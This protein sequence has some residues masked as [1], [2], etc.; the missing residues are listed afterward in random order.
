LHAH[1]STAAVDPANRINPGD[2][3]VTKRAF[4]QEHSP[5]RLSPVAA[6]AAAL[7]MA[8]S[9]AQ[10]QTA[11]S[12]QPATPQTQAER[13]KAEKEKAEREK[14]ATQTITVTG[15]R[16]GIENAINVKKNADS[17]VEAIS[18]EDIGKLP[19]TSVAEAISRLP[20]LSSQRNKSTGR[21]QSV[22]VRGLAPDFTTGTLN[23]RE[24][25]ST[26]D[27]RSVDFDQFPAEL[28]GG[29]TV[30]KSAESSQL[31]QG[32]G[33][34]IDLQTVRP[35]N[36][37]QRAAAVN[38]RKQRTGVGLPTDPG[39]GHRA[40]LS[41]VDQFMDRKLGVALGFTRFEDNG[42]GQLKFNSWGGW[43][44]DVPFNGENV[45]VPGGFTA[46]TEKTITKRDGAMA[47]L[48]FKPSKTFE[49]TLDF[50]YTKGDFKTSKK[51]LEG[52]IGGQSAGGYDPS[53][54]LTNVNVI[55][56]TNG[57]RIAASGTLS[58]YKGV[59]RNH[60]EGTVD[61]LTSFGWN[62]KL[63]LGDWSTALDLAQ[64]KV[65]KLSSR[66][67]T[68]AGQPGNYVSG[69]GTSGPL[70]SISWSGFNGSNFEQVRYTT[71]LNY[72]DPNVARLTDVNGWSGGEGSPQAGYASLPTT[73]DEIKSVRLSG[74]RPMN[75][76][77]INEMEI[78]LNFTDRLKTHSADEGRLVIRGSVDANGNV[79]AP[80]AAVTAPN[81]SVAIAGTTGLP[82]VAWNPTGSLGSV[83]DLA[84]KVDQDILN[85]SWDVSEKI[86]TAYM[87]NSVEWANGKAV[88]NFG[89]QLVRTEQTGSGFFVAPCTG[90]TA[91]TCPSVRR[92]SGLSFTD[93][94]PSANV[95]IDVGGDAKVR[96]GMGRVVSRPSMADMRASE[97]FGPANNVLQENFTVAPRAYQGSGGNPQLR[98][99]EATV[100]DISYEKYFGTKAYV[101]AAGF[102]KDLSTYIYN[103][104]SFVDFRR[105]NVPLTDASALPTGT[106][107]KPQNGTGG[108]VL[109]MELTASLPFNMF[110]PM[111]DGF[112]MQLN[113]SHTESSVKLPVAGVNGNDLG[114]FDIPLP[115]LSRNVT[116]V[117]WYYEKAGFQVALAKRYKSS[118]IGEV[119]DF[120]DNRQ[121]TFV[122]G[123][124]ITDVQ[125]AY[126]LQSGPLKGLSVLF[127]GN[128]LGKTPFQRFRPDTGAVVENVPTGK[129]YLL[130][131]NYKL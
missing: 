22:S 45:K 38:L 12:T 68:T 56:A 74:K 113:Y 71:S 67:E 10:A 52:A 130:G 61:R 24:Q 18:A 82:V 26:S 96:I 59:V 33:A 35:L 58:N 99:F 85:K 39:D 13:E 77:A 3:D 94:L 41:Y 111:L 55:T 122:K 119:T 84:G 19:D 104:L 48:Q 53:G 31:N 98:P 125:L 86:T 34:T 108:S 81:A 129:T 9:A 117:R 32:L 109:G 21:A 118:F 5:F 73:I 88:G 93:L 25:A 6:G 103:Q 107:R 110:T 126:E 15:I 57:D 91:A 101:A 100:L 46:D 90:T 75:L 123:E 76:G 47:V 69:N 105:Y 120:Q 14:N 78:G 44:P 54:V 106:F 2:N 4:D 1:A 36:F 62:N 40:S 97:S 37:T 27:S 60:D 64:S 83:Y 49:S 80:Y 115:G 128:N 131:I 87:R 20:G 23:G 63:S 7:L 8:M 102:Y 89:V 121:L 51:G 42:A 50:F 11:P 92:E 30:Y 112:G 127:Q 16:R 65:K 29:V 66:Y 28:L 17:I 79:L 124:I 72:S 70:G 95:A 116:N 43:T 114:S